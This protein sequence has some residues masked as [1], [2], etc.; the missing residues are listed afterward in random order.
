MA[1]PGF[2][3]MMLPVLEINADG[4]EHRVRDIAE[5]VAHRFTLSEVERAEMLSSGQQTVVHNRIAWARTYLVK[6]QLLESTRRGFVQ[7]T[8][9]GKQL[10]NRKPETINIAYLREH[11][12]IIKDFITGGTTYE[13]I[14]KPPVETDQ[15]PEEIL[16][17]AYQSLRH[18]LADEILAQVKAI[19]P[20]AFEQLVVQL[21]V[22]MGYGGT[23]KDAG[24]AV[25]QSGDGGIDG[26]IKEDRLGLDT[27]YLQAK[28]YADQPIGRPAIQ[29][30][31]GALQGVRA[32]RGIFITTSRFA[33]PAIEYAGNI[34]TKVVLIDGFQLAEYLIDFDLGVTKLNTFDVKRI[35]LDYFEQ[36]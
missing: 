5:E 9:N 23:L 20:Q 33:A 19:S 4:L 7:I 26:I 22:K 31:V 13:E 17:Q 15:T 8:D 36:A 35:D 21:L 2:Q 27:I 14:P 30:F 11:C 34:D 18:E 1:I 16:E 29:A 32:R 25:G 12:P 28:R 10:L 6:A 3:E 24:R